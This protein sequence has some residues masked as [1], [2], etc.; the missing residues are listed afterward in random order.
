MNTAVSPSPPRS[1]AAEFSVGLVQMSCVSDP[2]RN[3]EVALQGI[4]WAAKRGAEIICLQE[5]FASQYFCQSEDARFFD[6]AE[7]IPGRSTELCGALARELGVVVIVPVFEKRAS[8]LYHN[9]V[10]VI[11]ATG[12]LLGVYRKLHIP[13]DPQYFEKF[14]FTPGDLGY[15]VFETRVARIGVLICW[16]QWFPEAARLT[17]LKGAEVIFY[18]SAIGWLPS[19]RHIEGPVQYDAWRTI[20]QSHAI[21][22]GVYVA[23]VNRVGHEANPSGGLDFWGRS[24]ACDPRGQIVSEASEHEG[25]I[26]I[27]GC[28]RRV[29]EEQ[30]RGWPFLRDRRIDTYGPLTRRFLDDRLGQHDPSTS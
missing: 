25:D 10:A 14:Y 6:L 5:L 13:D 23:T 4:R 15:S 26:I 16:D 7:E 8:G 28:S 24:F 19:E 22:N 21:A 2:E 1:T 3:R 18:P 20:Q 17:A 30:R 12:V 27:A 11:D 29:L 9:S